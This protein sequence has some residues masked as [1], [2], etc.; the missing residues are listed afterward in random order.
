VVIS[1]FLIALI[2]SVS[3]YAIYTMSNN[4]TLSS[5]EETS[6]TI[7]DYTNRNVTVQLPVQRIACL[8]SGLTEVLCAVGGRDKIVARMDSAVFPPSLIDVTSFGS[9]TRNINLESLLSMEPDLVIASTYFPEESR[10]AVEEAGV[11]V[12]VETS[13]DIIR[14]EETI[15]Y[16]GQI[17]QNTEKANQI[18]EDINHYNDLVE[19]RIADAN[20]ETAN[21]TTFYVELTNAWRA[22]SDG[23]VQD[24]LLVSCGGENIIAANSSTT[25]PTVSPEV[26]IEANPDVIIKLHSGSWDLND[27]ETKYDEIV[28][29]PELQ[30]TSAVKSGRVYVCYWYL[31][32]CELYPVGKLYF[33]KWLWPDLFEDINPSEIHAQLAQDYFGTELTGT[34]VYSGGAPVT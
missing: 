30:E 23:S 24:M 7:T 27:F 6:V 14:L 33:A 20:L 28:N 18:L 21:K 15:E 9:S 22:M 26:V 25:S 4:D 32:T 13:G 5:P 31:T 3:A 17:L 29:R 8:S 10:E 19:Q 12:I 1:I 16:F 11:P 2:V 34:W